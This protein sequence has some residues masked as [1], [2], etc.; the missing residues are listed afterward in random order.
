MNK[1]IVIIGA[2]RGISYETAKNF[3]LKGYKVA[4]ISRTLSSLQELE[5]DLASHGITA[6]G[7]Q[8]D[9]SSGSS[10]KKALSEV[11]AA[12]GDEIEVLLYNAASIRPGQPTA[13]N[14][15]DFIYDFKVNVAG[16]LVAV[17]E[18][19]PFMKKDSGSILLTGGGL[20][21]NPNADVASLSVG[22]AGLRNLAYSLNQ[23]LTPNGIYV[24]TLTING[25][26]HEHTYFSGD[27][28]A[29][30]LF[31]MHEKK[32]EVDVVYEEA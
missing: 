19:L 32:E 18:I 24:G 4:L 31:D 3:G 21:L 28:I 8:G 2:G 9:V 30:A 12:F 7:F 25:F 16:A 14:V 11:R 10:M 1:T 5:S 26:V 27:K 29:G 22:K 17:Q 15:E 13:I 23:E 20:A 6:K